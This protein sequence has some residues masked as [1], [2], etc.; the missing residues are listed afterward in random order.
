MF[1]IVGIRPNS[2][3]KPEAF[4]IRLILGNH[5]GEF[6]L[7]IDAWLGQGSLFTQAHG[8]EAEQFFLLLAG[9]PVGGGFDCCESAHS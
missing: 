6:F 1:E 5:G 2:Q 9:Q 4:S 3:S 8:E 7:G